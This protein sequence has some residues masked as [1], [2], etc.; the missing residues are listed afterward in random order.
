[1]WSSP[2]ASTFSTGGALSTPTLT[3]STGLAVA[4]ARMAIGT[5]NVDDL[6]VQT[7]LKIQLLLGEMRRAGRLIGQFTS[8]NSGGQ[9]LTDEYTFGDVNSLYQILDS[10]LRGEHSRIANMMRSK[11]GELNT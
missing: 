7:A 6:C 1:M 11:L 4:P 3:Q 8:H 10:W 5:F 2:A 9:C